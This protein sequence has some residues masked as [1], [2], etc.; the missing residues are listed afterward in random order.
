LRAD[1]STL[2]S[3]VRRVKDWIPLVSVLIA[4]LVI[5]TL[6]WFKQRGDDARRWH[7][8]R[9]DAYAI[10]V[11]DCLRIRRAIANRQAWPIPPDA[12]DALADQYAVVTLLGSEDVRMQATY[13][14]RAISDAERPAPDGFEVE[15]RQDVL[16]RLASEVGGFVEAA[17]GELA[18]PPMSRDVE[19]Y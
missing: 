13:V 18:L 1:S 5:L 15:Q 14:M 4:K 6:F 16:Q 8:K 17:K 7:E 11:S 12:V 10:F 19:L 3:N 9:L 2:S